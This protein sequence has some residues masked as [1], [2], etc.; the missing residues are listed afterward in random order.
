[1]YFPPSF[2]TWEKGQ[3]RKGGI[4]SN[5]YFKTTESQ[6]I[7]YIF[8]LYLQ[9]NYIFYIL[10]LKDEPEMTLWCLELPEH[11]LN[12]ELFHL[13]LVNW[14]LQQDVSHGSNHVQG[15]VLLAGVRSRCLKVKHRKYNFWSPGEHKATFIKNC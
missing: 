13:L 3:K 7:L 4:C 9:S 5:T 11:N 10:I 2:S 12:Q 15:S 8:N 6:C 14:L 1:M